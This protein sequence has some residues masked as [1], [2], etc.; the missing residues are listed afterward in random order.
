MLVSKDGTKVHIEVKTCLDN[1]HRL[2]FRQDAGNL[3][4][5]PAVGAAQHL[6]ARTICGLLLILVL[7]MLL[8]SH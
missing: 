6:I 2:P 1:S 7:L 8:F 3:S 5:F 4:L